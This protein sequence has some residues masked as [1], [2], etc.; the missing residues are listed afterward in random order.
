[1]SPYRSTALDIRGQLRATAPKSGTLQKAV[2]TWG[3]DF[4]TTKYSLLANPGVDGV[5]IALEFR[6]NDKVDAK[7]IGMVQTA[8]STEM[9]APFLFGTLAQQA[10]L[11]QRA[12]AAGDVGEGRRIDRTTTGDFGNPLYATDAP[13]AADRLRTT[14]TLALWGHHGYRFT[15][16]SGKLQKKNALLKDT[17]QLSSA[18][19][20]SGQMFETTAV[21][22]DGTQEGTYYG[23][24]SWGW[25]KDVAGVVTKAP[26]TRVSKDAPS[27]AFAN[28]ARKW[29]TSKTIGGKS[30]IDL[31][32]VSR[33]YAV[34]DDTV[35]IE[36][37]AV[38]PSVEVGKL[39]KNTRVE[40][41]SRARNAA[42]NVGVATPWWKVTIVDGP[43]VGKIGWL[44]STA[45][46]TDP[47]P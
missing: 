18:K 29:N 3:G 32:I 44:L 40:V 8:I 1:M 14:P 19:K 41:T 2:V 7:K 9:G 45:V 36:D 43:H 35:V 20:S 11:K 38:A 16:A 37:P 34:V 13:G 47:V 23:S 15:D 39:A 22:V 21:A 26:L 12:V 30:T 33:G 17:P 42:F 31:P 4:E 24:V 46:A 27:N 28:A 6:P 25:S 10:V 5:D